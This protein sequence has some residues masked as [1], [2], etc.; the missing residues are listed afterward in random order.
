MNPLKSFR[1]VASLSRIKTDDPDLVREQMHALEHQIPWLYFNLLINAGAL[2]YTHNL[3]APDYLTVGVFS[4]MFI[5]FVAR[6][7]VWFR[8]NTTPYT[9]EVG[10]RRLKSLW[11]TGT[12]IGIIYNCW[13]LQLLPYG[14]AVQQGHVAFFLCVTVISCLCSLVQF[15][16]LT[17]SLLAVSATNTLVYFL[18][19]GNRVQIA[20]AISFVL[21][22]SIV[23][24]VSRILFQNFYEQIKAKRALSASRE[25]LSQLNTELTFHRDNLASE[26][27]RRTAQ[28]E[29]A[30]NAEKELNRLQNEFVSMV[31]H[32]FRTP[33]AVIDGSARRLELKRM[34]MSEDDVTNRLQTIRSSV[35]RL[36]GLIE[37]TLDASRLAAG[38]IQMNFAPYDLQQ[39][40][41]DCVAHQADI[42]SDFTFNLDID[43][44]PDRCIGD[45]RLM[46]NVVNNLLSNAVKY[47]GNSRQIHISATTEIDHVSVSVQDHG[48]GIPAADL[49]MISSRFFR[50]SNTSGIQGTGIGL[51]LVNSLI[52]EYHGHVV[53]ESEEGAWTKVTFTLPTSPTLA[54][55]SMESPAD[56]QA[57]S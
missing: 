11:I 34:S 39:L 55:P 35:A 54:E 41:R 49:T 40:I 42:H 1:E 9:H 10:V 12:L 33:L 2:V 56:M 43:V 36:S 17:L 47:S 44:V 15:P 8:P 48:I 27:Q 23:A 37:R 3:V 20:M 31:S 21:V 38:K 46:E 26:V 29:E 18:I 57:V 4:L 13:A 7:I 30:L 24:F 6:M 51:N 50:A 19:A 25:K 52:K 45:A 16:A 53:I 28:L 32:E 5:L 14:N 22:I